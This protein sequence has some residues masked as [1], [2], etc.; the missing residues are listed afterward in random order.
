MQR[1][2]R[3]LRI[4]TVKRVD[5][6]IRLQ[7]LNLRVTQFAAF[8]TVGESMLSI[9]A[10]RRSADGRFA[11]DAERTQVLVS[12]KVEGMAGAGSHGDYLARIAS[13]EFWQEYKYTQRC[14][15]GFKVL[16]TTPASHPPHSIRAKP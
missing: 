8:N 1:L 12:L 5:G 14:A 2:S 11:A 9:V 7:A 10:T 3:P 4:P 13:C 15:N 6:E 16:W